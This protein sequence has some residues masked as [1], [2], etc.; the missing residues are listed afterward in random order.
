MPSLLSGKLA[1]R[2]IEGSGQSSFFILIKYGMNDLW[3]VVAKLV[4]NRF[5]VVPVDDSSFRA[6]RID[7][8]QHENAV[9]GDVVPESRELFVGGRRELENGLVLGT[10]LSS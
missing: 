4:S 7:D 8:D 1:S 10:F 5:A 6:V 2:E 9:D 3:T